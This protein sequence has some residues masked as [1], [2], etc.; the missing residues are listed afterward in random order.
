MQQLGYD[1]DSRGIAHELLQDQCELV[2]RAAAVPAAADQP[3]VYRGPG[4]AASLARLVEVVPPALRAATIAALVPD[5][6]KD[7][8]PPK[9]PEH[10][11][12]AWFRNLVFGRCV[13]PRGVTA[14]TMAAILSVMLDRRDE[15]GQQDQVCLDCGLS[16]PYPRQGS[17]LEVQKPPFFAACPHCGCER[18][19]WAHLNEVEPRGDEEE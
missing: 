5:H 18:W 1:A 4:L 10:P 6:G 16:R 13:L 3:D 15:C 2:C 17:Y 19:T 7:G 9:G 11:V 14:E 12:A 8:H